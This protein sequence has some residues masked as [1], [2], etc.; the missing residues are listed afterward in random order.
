MTPSEK[1]NRENININYKNEKKKKIFFVSSIIPNFKI[2]N[3]FVNT[4]KTY[5]DINNAS[6]VL[7]PMKGIDKND[8]FYL[9][10]DWKQIQKYIF[11]NYIFNKNLKAFDILLSP[12][13]INPLTGLER[14]GQKDFS[15]I[16]ASPKQQMKSVPVSLNKLPHVLW[17]TGTICRN[18]NYKN[19]RIGKLGSQDHIIGG[20]IVEIDND[21]FYIR[22]VQA[23]KDGSFIDLNKK[24][25]KDTVK[26]YN[27]P[28]LYMGDSHAGWEDLSALSSTFDQIEKL[29]IKK[30]FVGDL[31]DGTSISHHHEHDIHSQIDRPKHLNTLEKELNTVANYLINIINKFPKLKIYIIRSNHDEHLDKYLKERKFINDRFNYE[32]SLELSLYVLQNKNPIEE[33]IKINYPKIY[34]NLIWLKRESSYKIKNIE[35]ACHGDK[36]SD[37]KWGS[38]LNLE[39]SYGSCV[40]GHAHSPQILRSVYIVGTNSKFNLPYTKGAALSWLHANC[41]IYDNGQ[42]Q[43]LIS[44]NGKWKL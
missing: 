22:P 27:S 33:W 34:K 42:R 43:L 20:L 5:C 44:F 26:N 35:L 23:S 6:F 13:Q 18:T 36:G 28:I 30:I 4:I 8:F 10:E 38:A 17:T 32:L 31:F 7:L 2:N 41:I 21:N 12:Q 1:L 24:Y 29:K 15:L 19:N 16:I 3:N 25:Y 11:T 39:K 14:Y 37:G 9:D 40:V